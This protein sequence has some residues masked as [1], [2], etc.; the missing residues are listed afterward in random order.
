MAAGVAFGAGDG[1]FGN[2]DLMR[3]TWLKTGECSTCNCSF[4]GENPVNTYLTDADGQPLNVIPEPSQTVV[5]AGLLSLDLPG[6]VKS[7][8]ECDSIT[9]DITWAAPSAADTC[10]VQDFACEAHHAQKGKVIDELT[11]GGGEHII[12]D[13]TYCCWATNKCGAF[14]GFKVGD[15]RSNSAEGCWTVTVN[16]QTALDV[17][18]ELS[19]AMSTKVG[20]VER[21]IEFEAFSNCIQGPQVFCDNVTFGGNFFNLIGHSTGEFKMPPGQFACLT[22]RDKLHTLR[23]CALR[24]DGN[25]DCVGGTV[26]ATFK[27]DPFFGGNWLINGNLDAWKKDNDKASHDVI[28]IQ[29]F[30]QFVAQFGQCYFDGAPVDCS[31]PTNGAT[32]CGTEGPHADINGDGI[33]DLLDFSFVSANFLVSS[34]DCCCPGST[35]NTVGRT[36]IS[37]VE[38][39][40]MG[41]TD[42]IVAD[43]NN[44]GMLD[45]NDMAAFL[46]GDVP[47]RKGIQSRTGLR[48]TGR[49]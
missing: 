49:K 35:G 26:F 39:R 25:L 4:G 24:T 43:L 8:V 48:S 19:P 3:I 1:P 41:L 17:E 34:K 2:A 23:A 27:G 7:N 32:P 30:G 38:L 42:L 15:A 22:A 36:A 45:L 28:D 29:D 46:S 10:G 16:D 20:G 13:S 6:S 14:A 9:V 37:V 47:S 44:D 40:Q 18:I 21:C 33:A 12:G 5:S 11:M 31:G